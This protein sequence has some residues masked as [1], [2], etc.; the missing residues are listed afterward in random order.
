MMN[1]VWP[2]VFLLAPLPWLAGRFLR[3]LER[4]Q[5]ALTVPDLDAFRFESDAGLSQVSSP[6]LP[7]LLMWLCWLLLLSACARPQWVGEPMNLPVS[8]RDLMLAVD[9]SGSMNTEDMELNNRLVDRLTVV[10]RV[11]DDFLEKRVGDRVGLILFGTNAYLQ[12]P[13]T[14]DLTTVKQ[15][16][17]EAPVGIAGGKTAIGDAIG[18]AAKRLAS[19]PENSRVLILLT[20]GANNVGMV[21]P[22]KAAQLASQAHIRI[23]T[24]GM[25]SDQLRLP[26]ILGSFG[27]RI[28][29]P[30]SDLDEE[31]LKKI[32]EITGGRYFRARNTMEL[33]QIYDLLDQLEPVQQEDKLYRPSRALYHWPLAGALLCFLLALLAG[34]NLALPR[35]YRKRPSATRAAP[36]VHKSPDVH[37]TAED[38]LVPAKGGADV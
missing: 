37:P 10:K 1:F 17:D 28:V 18:L 16:L 15:F 19:R 11:V 8:G 3:P 23:Y 12:A 27:S 21:E 14:F 20:D 24:I 5:A 13:L 25:G 32:A 33:Q 29:N 35:T 22:E 7:L 34:N 6:R 36:A 2:W 26:G 4:T 30:S 31:A 9:I 38:S